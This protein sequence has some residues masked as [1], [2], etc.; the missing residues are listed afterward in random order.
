MPACKLRSAHASLVRELQPLQCLHD[1]SPR[2]RLPA[3]K[4]RVEQR[5]V[6]RRRRSAVS[7]AVAGAVSGRVSVSLCTMSS[8][9]RPE[10]RPCP[11]TSTCPP[12]PVRNEFTHGTEFE[13]RDQREVVHAIGVVS[14]GSESAADP[15]TSMRRESNATSPCQ[16]PFAPCANCAAEVSWNAGCSARAPRF[17]GNRARP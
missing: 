2:R 5:G 6:R 15:C 1:A 14:V 17:D 13:P 7:G 8:R 16:A 11:I 3:P 4:H 9:V 10:T 12:K